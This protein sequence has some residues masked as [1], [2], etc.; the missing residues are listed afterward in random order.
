MAASVEEN[1]R[2][3]AGE[4][5]SAHRDPEAV[6]SGAIPTGSRSIP[7]ARSVRFPPIGARRSRL[8]RGS[9]AIPIDNFFTGEE[10]D[11]RF[12]RDVF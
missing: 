4:I 3:G 5:R 10:D 8:H 11:A 2:R 12:G 6:N 1:R 7:P 9:A